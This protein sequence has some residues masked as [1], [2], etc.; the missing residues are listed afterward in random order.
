MTSSP[1]APKIGKCRVCGNENLVP[2]ISIGS[3][4]LSSVFPVALDYRDKVPNWPMDL[5]MCRKDSDV[6]CGSVQL[7]HEIDLTAMYDSY[8]YTS[9]TNSSMVPILQ[10]VEKS[11]RALG[12][13]KADDVVLDIGGNDG[14]LLSFFK[15]DPFS[16]VSIDPAHNVKVLFE[17]PR[18]TAVRD[19]FSA[20]AFNRASKKKAKLA[21]SVAMFYHLHDPVG[22]SKQVESVLDDNGVWIIQMA[23]LPAMIRTNMYDNIVHEH[24]G[25]YGAQHMKRIMELAG[26]EVFDVTLNNVYGGSF[27]IFIKK[28]GAAAFPHTERYEALLNK[29][30]E[31]GIFELKTYEDF[32]ARIE[33][34]RTDLI[35][36]CKKIKAEGKTIWVYG[37]STKGN[38]ILQYCGIG[39]DEI[40]A[41]ADANPF[42]VGKYIIGSDIPIKDEAA[43]RAAKPDYL[44]ALPYSFVAGFLAREAD[45]VS[46]GTKFIVPLPGVRIVP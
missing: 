10:D 1:S 43:M 46:K 37:A 18:F 20:E 33:K 6:R 4:Y 32:M 26:L 40:A 22:F 12:H 36:L 30:V 39:K 14:T 35:E 27:R 15:D 23:Y 41:A 24:V 21:F 34:T 11:G 17:S 42:K 28:N 8:P 3:Q 19:F 16:L 9:S 25:Y 2:C 13:L 5:V 44:L 29:E 45:L 31:E 38:T 7:A